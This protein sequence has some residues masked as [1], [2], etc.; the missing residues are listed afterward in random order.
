[1]PPT[2]SILDKHPKYKEDF[3]QVDGKVYCTFCQCLIDHKKKHNLDA[4]LKT[5]KHK[6][7]KKIA[8]ISQDLPEHENLAM[9]QTQ[10]SNKQEINV[11]IIKAFTKADIPLEKIGK[12]KSFFQKYCT[13][14]TYNFYIKFI[15]IFFM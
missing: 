12:L 2:F 14:G 8:E 6:K 9:L 5:N 13:N 4:H 3:Y 15:L 11:D 7:K 1:M 10:I